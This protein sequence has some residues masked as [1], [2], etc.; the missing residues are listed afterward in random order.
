MLGLDA[1]QTRLRRAQTIL[2]LLSALKS[3][4]R[5]IAAARNEVQRDKNEYIHTEGSLNLKAVPESGDCLSRLIDVT[6]TGVGRSLI[7]SKTHI[8]LSELSRYRCMPVGP[9]HVSPDACPW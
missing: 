3:D 1:Q 5:A 7:E 4:R 8:I 9:I 6:R 2:S